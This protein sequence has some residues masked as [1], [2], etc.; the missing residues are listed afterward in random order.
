MCYI[1]KIRGDHERVGD[2]DVYLISPQNTEL[3]LWSKRCGTSKGFNI[4]L[5]DQSIEFF[6]CPINTGKIYKPDLKLNVFHGQSSK[7]VWKVRVEDNVAGEGGRF[8]EFSLEVCTNVSLESPLLVKNSD[9][10][11]RDY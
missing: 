11:L 4:G 6:K 2:L 10:F 8:H 3:Q 7:G 9:T 5:D 1:K